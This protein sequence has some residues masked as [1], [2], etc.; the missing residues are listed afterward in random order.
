MGTDNSKR[1]ALAALAR[2]R[3]S[4]RWPGY[5][6]IGEYHDGIYECDHVSPYSKA[7]G[8]TDARIMVLLQDWASHDAL[9]GPVH[10]ER[11]RLGHDPERWTNRHLKDLLRRHLG[12]G[13]GEVYATNVFP[14]VK[15]G[16]M[17]APIPM[18]DM[19]PAAAMFAL[20]QV[21]IVRP[22][23]ALCLGIRTFNA[24]ARAAGH[25]SV[26]RLDDAIANPF[27]LGETDVRCL[28]HTSQQ[29][30]NTRNRSDPDRVDRDWRRV[31]DALEERERP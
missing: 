26:A 12:V 6:A 27:T 15:P 21:E 3:R 11:V 22:Q 17:S 8:N 7:A 4:T 13:F 30:T 9:S 5:G 23:I 10:P 25:R 28:A 20:P 1:D 19:V 2:K 31:A 29:A 24:V 16:G 18:R 14:F